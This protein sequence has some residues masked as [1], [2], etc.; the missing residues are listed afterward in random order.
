MKTLENKETT[1]VQNVD[2]SIKP[3]TYTDLLKI[4]LNNPPQG[5]FSVTEM[6]Q[7][8]KIIDS[9]ETANGKIKLEDADYVLTSTCVK[10]FKWAQM[11]KDILEFID[12]VLKA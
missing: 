6:R 11:H 3:L 4:C 9:L 12:H 10:D 2:G 5:G 8:L 1:I 7:R